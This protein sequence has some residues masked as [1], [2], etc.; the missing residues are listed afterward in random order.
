MRIKE[1]VKSQKYLYRTAK[2]LQT[3]PVYYFYKLKRTLSFKS[4]SINS[5]NAIRITKDKSHCFFGY[6]DKC[7]WNLSGKYLIFLQVPFADRM[8]KPGEEAQLGIIDVSNGITS[9][10]Q[11]ILTSTRAWSWQQG[12]M[13]QWLGSNPE[14][15]IIFNDYEHK[16]YCSKIIDL[17]SGLKRILPLPIYAISRDGEKALSI[18]FDRLHFAR[19]GYGYVASTCK[20]LHDNYPKDDGIWFM[21]LKSGEYK[22]IISLWEIINYQKKKIFDQ[23]FHYF[24]HLEF[25]QKGNRFIFLH[26]W[27][28]RNIRYSRLFV[29]NCDGSNLVCLSDHGLVSHF[30]WRD[31]EH[32]LAW[33]RHLAG[34]HYYLFKD[35]SDQVAIVGK[36]ILTEDGHPSYSPDGNYILTDTYPD[37]ERMRSILL[38]DIKR[39]SL[40]TLGRYFSPFQYDGPIRCDLHPRWN[41]NGQMICFD[42]VHEGCRAMYVLDV[43]EKI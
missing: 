31:N 14:R 6:Y 32:I 39:N 18:N 38:Y 26:R 8:P 21:D 28:H 19:P 20:N 36:G 34:D 9:P 15:Q 37:K 43:T 24:N 41:R 7:P 29:A 10:K 5:S 33:T 25:N 30:T 23:S 17:H 22:L 13:M 12:A 2:W 3:R 16:K 27:I 40:K 42:S 35:K 1:F 4:E 11:E